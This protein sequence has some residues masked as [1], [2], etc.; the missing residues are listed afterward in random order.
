[1]QKIIPFLWFESQ[2]EEAMNFYTSIFPNSKV[3]TVSRYG[4]EGAEVS[5]RPEGSVMV[6]S[7][8]LNGQRFDLINGGPEFKFTEAISFVINCEDQTEVDHYWDALTAE[9]QE[10]QCGWLKDK[11]GVSWQVTPTIM[12]KLMSDPDKAKSGRVMAAM[13]KMKKIDIAKLQEAYDQA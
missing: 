4:K 2:A 6:A 9:G 3:L 11:F 13:L 5:G 7:V 10:I 1:M 12:G 8:E